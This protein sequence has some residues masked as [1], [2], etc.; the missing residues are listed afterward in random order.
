MASQAASLTT[1]ASLLRA[2]SANSAARGDGRRFL[3]RPC[4]LRSRHA[5]GDHGD[6]RPDRSH[7]TGRHS[8]FREHAGRCRGH[9]HGDLVG[10]DFKQI[11]T[12]LDRIARRFEPLGDLAFATV[13]PS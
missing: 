10:L 9:L 11:V 1:M 6:D 7:V 4:P 13:S 3:S 8:D 2:G 5:V 12:R